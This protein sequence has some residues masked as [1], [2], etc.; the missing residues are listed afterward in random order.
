SPGTFRISSQTLL[1]LA[2][3]A[4]KDDRLAADQ[5]NEALV[6]QGAPPLKIVTEGSLRKRPSN[7][8]LIGTAG[9]KWARD[10]LKARSC[11]L[12]PEMKDEGY[13]LD[14]GSDG[15]LIAAES[16]RGRFYA[17]QTL[18]QLVYRDKKVVQVPRV[19]IHDW[20][21]QK[22][23]GITDDLSRGQVSTLE[24]FKKII[25][26]LARYK[27]NIYSPYIEDIFVFKN[28]SL[29]GKGRGALS[30]A[31]VRELDAYAKQYHV[32]LIP[33]F[34]T[35]GHWEN[36]LL[37]P[38][39]VGYGEF[40]GAHTLNVSDERVYALL[41]E[42]IGELAAAFSSPFFNMAADESWDV[43]LGANKER[44]AASDIATVH[45]EH[46]KRLFAILKKYNK[47]P[48][49]Y[50]DIILN[51]PDILE[52]IPKDVIIVD[53]QYWA[54]QQYPSPEVFRNAGFPFVV[55]PAV[56]NFT[57]PFPNYLNTVLNIRNLT[58]DGYRNGSLGV[59][60][61]NWNDFGGE[62]LRELNYYGFAWTAECAWQPEKADPV[63]FDTKFFRQFFGNEEAGRLGQTIY[64]ILSNP[65]NQM[66]WHDLWRHP[67]LPLRQ[68]GMNHLWRVQSIESTMP[69]VQS[70]I[71]EASATALRNK[72]HFPYL[73]FITNLNLW[74]AEKLRTGELI[75][76]WQRDSTLRLN[77]DSLQ[78]LVTPA[79]TQTG[80]NLRNVQREF[81]TL[82]LA[83]NRPDNLDLLMKRYDRQASYWEE[84][85]QQ[86]EQSDPTIPSKW[87][88][89]PSANPRNRDTSATQVPRAFF[90]IVLDHNRQEPPAG[91]QVMADTYAKVFVNGSE[92]GELYARFSLSLLVES[93]RTKRW[94]LTPHLRPGRN[95]I[96]V[97]GANYNTFGSAGINILGYRADPSG[98]YETI[99]LDSLIKVSDKVSEGWTEEAFDDSRWL[100]AS[101]MPYPNAVIAPDF[102][103]NRPSWIEQ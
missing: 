47:K 40:P 79:A 15:I 66:H 3:G 85:M 22:M 96:A 21:L 25:R 27:L 44:V 17:V 42:M 81:R 41:D 51:N 99:V 28:H 43:G 30:S 55:S 61:S 38:E 78:A 92:L 53:W 23:R 59:L 93:H 103:R 87:M 24:N 60:T 48:L 36:I 89:H 94:D 68:S 32:E 35:L 91:I 83:T 57:G 100:P 95:V 14:V 10:L 76:Q 86:P 7:F 52:K 64:A 75:K 73:R 19:S 90:R 50:G 70:L 8:I 1:V 102:R 39:Y 82:W 9:S 16:P 54:G 29:I 58:R 2:D 72:D 88:Y 46:Y 20:P 97:E 33:I 71:D 12:T 62:A 77:P 18:L 45:A 6:E 84:I 74:F 26:F 65:F 63:A 56:W 98:S 4:G 5:L 11:R 34:E 101:P 13:V 31:E 69:F 80:E 67:L 49:M 37:M